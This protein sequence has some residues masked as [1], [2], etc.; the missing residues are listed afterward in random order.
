M[1]FVRERKTFRLHFEGD[2]WDGLEV[3]VKAVSVGKFLDMAP[4]LDGLSGMNPEQGLSGADLESIKEAF[5]SFADV[6]LEWNLEEDVDGVITAVPAD[7]DGLL[8]QD[9]ELI[10][11]VMS[12]WSTAMAG[13]SGPLPRPSPSGGTAQEVSLPMVALSASPPS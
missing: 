10:Q 2:Q 9:L 7:I 4:L 11:A 3:R 1:G 13:A 6:I 5:Q 12:A 8:S